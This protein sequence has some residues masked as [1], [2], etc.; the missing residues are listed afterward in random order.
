MSS[1][2]S[3]VSAAHKPPGRI[4]RKQLRGKIALT[5]VRKNGERAFSPSK[6]LRH[7][8]GSMKY[9]AGR[10]SAENSF[11]L[12]KAACRGTCFLIMNG[13]NLID[14]VSIEDLGNKAGADSLDP[15]RS[16]FAAREHRRLCGFDSEDF[17]ARDLLLQ[18]FAGARDRPAGA[19]TDNERIEARSC[20]CKNLLRRRSAMHVRVCRIAKLLWHEVV[21]VC[22]ENLF[23]SSNGA[24]H[25]V[26]AR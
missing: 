8:A 4:S 5:G 3:G 14:H 24:G 17:Q 25:G 20:R 1:R 9:R 19:D 6:I 15:M 2:D 11:E 21:R 26:A 18:Y 7:G 16:G 12:C 13:E 22:G 10:H 23:R